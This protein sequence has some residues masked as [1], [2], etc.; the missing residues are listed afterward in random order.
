LETI[1]LTDGSGNMYIKNLQTFLTVARLLNFG[2]AA[3]T[4][5]YSQST[6]SEHIHALEEELGAR[7]FERLGRKVFL[8]EQ[9]ETLLPLAERLVRDADAINGLFKE[10]GDV[11]GCLN[12]GAAESLCVFWLPPLLKEYRIRYPKVQI[13]IKVGNCVDFPLWLQQ[14]T[15]DVA[16][17]LNNEPGQEQLRQIE[18]FRGETV[19]VASPDHEL[20]AGPELA[21][22]NLGGQ[23]L[24]LAE[25]Y[26]G[27]P[28]ELKRLLEREGVR[29]N[30]IMEFGSLEA[31][32]NCVKSGLGITLLPKI[33]VEGDLKRGE[34][35]IFHW[36]GQP[37]P[38]QAKM[39]FHR[40][41]WVSPPIAALEKLVMAE[42]KRQKGATN[43]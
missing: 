26:C 12:I 14:N 2:A 32:K 38:I 8:T 27:Y 36:S 22:Q 37:I 4:L 9:G 28:M 43:I 24:L 39:V 1:D 33:V 23:T 34:L 41:K 10:G 20:A 40:D 3:Q 25:G 5:N 35:V 42:I 6:V 7:L 16:F 15:I 17:S 29:A 13:N 21:P 30:T 31:I 11:S 18:L 19:F